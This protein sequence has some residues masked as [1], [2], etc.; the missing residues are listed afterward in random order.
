M[1]IYS[2]QLFQMVNV[3]NE[4]CKIQKVDISEMINSK[5]LI[6]SVA[7]TPEWQNVENTNIEG[8]KQR[9]WK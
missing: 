5:H 6:V 4:G 2:K 3:F 1:H 9:M 8:P 7:K